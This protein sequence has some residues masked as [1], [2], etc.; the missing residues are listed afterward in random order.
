MAQEELENMHI[1]IFEE[2]NER[3][4]LIYLRQWGKQMHACRK[5]DEVQARRLVS[6]SNLLEEIL[7][8]LQQVQNL[9][10][11]VE[12]TVPL[13]TVVTFLEK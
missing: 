4:Q 8:N 7:H 9:D 12:T 11:D 3:S 6:I 5:E 13:P 1:K 10:N 2:W